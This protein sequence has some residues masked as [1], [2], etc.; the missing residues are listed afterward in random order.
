MR[1]NPLS[2]DPDAILAVE[3]SDP[4]RSGHSE[5]RSV[6]PGAFVIVQHDIAS[7]D[8]SDSHQGLLAGK[9]ALVAS[10]APLPSHGNRLAQFLR[11]G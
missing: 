1:L 10:T 8:A 7:G 9:D 2:L 4:P 11:C 5:Q 6:D 3:V